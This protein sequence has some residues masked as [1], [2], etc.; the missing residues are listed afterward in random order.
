[1]A[2]SSRKHWILIAWPVRYK[3]DGWD[4]K[5]ATTCSS[6]DRFVA[7]AEP[8]AAHLPGICSAL[9]QPH[10]LN[11]TPKTATE[12]NSAIKYISSFTCILMSAISLKILVVIDPLKQ[13]IQAG[14]ATIEVEVLSH[15]CTTLNISAV[16]GIKF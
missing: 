1:M 7:S 14:Q 4:G 13:I 3:I 2:N 16:N 10:T 15:L 9:E 5:C 6:M 11:H 8:L 12:V